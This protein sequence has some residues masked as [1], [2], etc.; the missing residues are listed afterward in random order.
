[1]Q[2]NYPI[3]LRISDYHPQ[4]SSFIRERCNYLSSFTFLTLS[5]L[6]MLSTGCSWKQKDLSKKIVLKV[7]TAELSAQQFSEEL[8]RRASEFD[9]INLKDPMIQKR[10]KQDIQ[11]DF[12]TNEIL[13]MFARQNKIIV[14][15]EMLEAEVNAIREGYPDDETFRQALLSQN[16]TLRSWTQKVRK[17]ILK[18]LVIEHL[19]LSTD[20]PGDEEIKNY[21]SENMG[22]YQRPEQIK[23]RQIVLANES[24]AQHILDELEKGKDF[25]DL[26]KEFSIAPEGFDREG[27]LP[28]LSKGTLD[29]FDQAFF[30]KKGQRSQIIKSPYGYHII[31]LLDKRP[32]RAL[33]LAEVKNQI[34]G[35]LNESRQQAV[36]TKWLEE[37]LKTVEVF[38]NTDFINAITIDHQLAGK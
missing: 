1:M 29:V 17:N 32:A 15:K 35:I 24:D 19:N 5:F 38:E 14:K 21:Y 30:L 36:F 33:S 3:R 12:I 23:L 16:L 25:R 9:L 28:W 22:L 2:K 6:L 26:A 18:K 31:E 7:G 8:A 37:E 20:P 13:E 4:N 34:I 10:L 11:A 27:Q